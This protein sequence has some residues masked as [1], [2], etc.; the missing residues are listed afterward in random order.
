MPKICDMDGVRGGEDPFPVELWLDDES[1]RVFVRGTN[2]GGFACI[3]IDACD[4]L[5]WFKIGDADA[6]LAA[7]IAEHSK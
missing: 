6:R 3:D 5:Q 7:S 2:E 1:G 4:L